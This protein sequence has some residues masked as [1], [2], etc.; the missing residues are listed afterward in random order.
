MAIAIVAAV[1][2]LAAY[3]FGVHR[4]FARGYYAALFD[5][6]IGEPEEYVEI[7][8]EDELEREHLDR[9]GD[10]IEAGREGRN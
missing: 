2:V 10:R 9:Y 7:L 6:S 1:A 5:L 8:L 3:L 4:G